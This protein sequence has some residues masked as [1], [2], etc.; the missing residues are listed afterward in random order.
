M[1]IE[2]KHIKCVLVG[3]GNIGVKYDINKKDLIQTHTKGII[4]NKNLKLICGVDKKKISRNLFKK[5]YQIKAVKNLETVTSNYR[6]DIFI[7]ATPSNSHLNIII[8]IIKKFNPKLIICEKPMGTNFKEAKKIVNLCKTKKIKLIINYIRRSDPVYLKLKNKLLKNK[9]THGN[10]YYNHGFIHSCS[11]YVNLLC[12]FFGKCKK[13]QI[14]AVKKKLENDYKIDCLLYFKKAFIKINSI[15]NKI[16]K[17]FIL[18]GNVGKIEKSKFKGMLINGKKEKNTMQYYQK[19]FYANVNKFMSGK[20]NYYL[21]F[22]KEALENF[23]LMSNIIKKANE[24]LKIKK[25]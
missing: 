25:I 17:E 18:E 22:G 12:F 4:N 13:F 1:V 7:V 2:N 23:K 3:L 5:E 19:S 20:K 10:F 15:N 6:P 21:C 16:K 24:K 8:K 11:H 14:V 9:F